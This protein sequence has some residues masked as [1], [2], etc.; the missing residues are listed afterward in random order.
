VRRLRT[1]P[2]APL[3]LAG[4]LAAPL[5]FVALMAMSLAVEKPSVHHI[6]K[7]GKLLTTFG[8]P[9]GTTE[10]EI[11][12]LAVLPVVVLVVVGTGAMYLGRAGVILTSLGAIALTVAL[13]VPF[14]GWV[15]DHVARYP[16]GAD[17]IPPSAGSQDIYLRGEWEGTARHTAQQLGIATIAIAAAALA[18]LVLLEVRR[19]RG[20]VPPPPPP[21]PE[22]AAGGVPTT[23]GF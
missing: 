8:D 2:R 14:D 9:S 4:I 21:P 19:R 15:R 3:A 13:L 7:H 12:L 11:W 16:V 17:L 6:V 5:F 10:A 23:T 18:I 20:V 22:I 1:A